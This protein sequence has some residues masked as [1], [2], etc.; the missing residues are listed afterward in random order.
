LEYAQQNGTSWDIVSIGSGAPVDNTDGFAALANIGGN[1][2]V[3]YITSNTVRYTFRDSLGWH[4]E[5]VIPQS[6]LDVS[7]T[8]VGTTPVICYTEY[9]GVYLTSREGGTWTAPV[10]VDSAIAP[11]WADVDYSNGSLNVAY[12]DVADPYMLVRFGTAVVPEPG[13]LALVTL[14]AFGLMRRYRPRR[15]N[16]I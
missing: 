16:Q 5:S 11:Y 14:G 15:C 1:P 12:G 10:E 3:A 2:S 6:A 8:S 7:L 13:T 9:G 4:D